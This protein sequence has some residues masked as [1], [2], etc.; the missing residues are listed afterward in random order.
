MSKI[1]KL[2]NAAAQV[3][4]TVDL[5]DEMLESGYNFG[6]EPSDVTHLLNALRDIAYGL[7]AD[8]EEREY[9]LERLKEEVRKV[10]YL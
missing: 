3:E 9:E 1:T 6:F 10:K 7:E 4:R 8:A 5:L 2:H